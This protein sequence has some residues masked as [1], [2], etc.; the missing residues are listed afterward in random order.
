MATNTKSPALIGGLSS[1]RLQENRLRSFNLT[2]G[3]NIGDVLQSIYTIRNLTLKLS[4]TVQFGATAPAQADIQPG[5]EWGFIGNVNLT[6]NGGTVLASLTGEQL[7]MLNYLTGRNLRKI[8][9][10]LVTLPAANAQATFT[11]TLSLPRAMWNAHKPL[12]FSLNANL[13]N[14][15]YFSVT[16]NQLTNFLSTVGATLVS[17]NLTVYQEAAAPMNASNQPMFTEWSIVPSQISFAGA[18]GLTDTKLPPTQIYRAVMMSGKASAA[19]GA[20]DSAIISELQ[21]L[22]QGLETVHYYDID[23]MQAEYYDEI[24]LKP[25]TDKVFQCGTFKSAA[26]YVLDFA[27]FKYMTESYN[28]IGYT[29]VGLNIATS[30]AGVINLLPV[31]IYPTTVVPAKPAAAA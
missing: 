29:N 15:V 12:D 1:F 20:A 19:V 4:V 26:W 16:A 7:V 27:R 6:V 8:P 10:N 28:T 24:G 18:S 30:G 21:V 14:Q 22:S 13:Q 9:A 5:D 31:V 11:S 17:A 3:G 2:A 23:S 25:N